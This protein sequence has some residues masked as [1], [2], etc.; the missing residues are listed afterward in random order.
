MEGWS[1][2]SI[3][4]TVAIGIAIAVALVR[5]N[6][7]SK[8]SKTRPSDRYYAGDEGT[9]RECDEEEKKRP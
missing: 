6:A 1:G 2:F 7:A 8:P 5:H 3:F 9:R 4:L